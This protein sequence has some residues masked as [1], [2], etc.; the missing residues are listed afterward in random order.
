MSH[1]AQAPSE[2]VQPSRH[3]WESLVNAL[4]G[5]GTRQVVPLR[6][7]E[8]FF[9]HAYLLMRTCIGWIGI[10]L[11]LVFIVG[12]LFLLRNLQVRESIS[13]YYHGSMHDVFV[14]GL[15]TIGFILATYM[16]ARPL[17][18][19]FWYSS[20][21]GV[22]VLG[23]V[24][25]PTWRPGIIAGQPLCGEAPDVA[26]CSAVQSRLH[27]GLTAHVHQVCAI[28]FILF[29]ALMSFV[30]SR[31]EATQGKVRAARGHTIAGWLIVAF[32]AWALIGTALG[33]DI[34]SLTPLYVGEVGAIW[35]FG[36]SWLAK[37]Y[38]LR[39]F[40][41]LCRL[42]PAAVRGRLLPG[43]RRSPGQQS[44]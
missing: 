36:G 13:S 32:G 19:D 22:A 10:A 35:S 18:R 7:Q 1:V 44:G 24:F 16:S 4:L 34:G 41:G 21:A 3:W 9:T 25:F 38:G 37:G 17:R 29:L 20:V 40:R 5:P 30:F 43:P 6:E 15:T 23:V 11:P 33:A 14:G 28:V 31:S 8:R 26:G 27:E 39:G 12:E 2:P 42:L